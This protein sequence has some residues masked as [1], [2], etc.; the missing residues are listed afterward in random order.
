MSVSMLVPAGVG[1]VS[2]SAGNYYTPDVNGLVSVPSSSVVSLLS[3]GCVLNTIL[4]KNLVAATGATGTSEQTLMSYTLPASVLT[5][6]GQALKI[7]AY[8]V[9]AGNTNNKTFKL[10]FGSEVIATPAAAT[11]AKNWWLELEVYRTG[12]SAQSVFGRG[13]VDTT[14]VTP[15]N[16]TGTETE[17]SGIVIKATGTGG[18]S[19]ADCIVSALIV[20]ALY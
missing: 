8:G 13:T 20:E 12:L 16:T 9:T 18:T 19:G 6:N 7:R 15:Y 5:E 1:S 3:A 2:D 4:S 10:Y 11:N 14:S 17:T